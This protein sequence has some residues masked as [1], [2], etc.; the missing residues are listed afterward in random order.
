MIEKDETDGGEQ[1]ALLNRTERVRLSQV[2]VSD[3]NT[4]AGEVVSVFGRMLT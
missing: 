3:S 4:V 1:P 2:I